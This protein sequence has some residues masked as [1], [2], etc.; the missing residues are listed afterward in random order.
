[1]FSGLGFSGWLIHFDEDEDEDEE[2]DDTH[3]PLRGAHSRTEC[4][5][6]FVRHL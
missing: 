6:I 2:D 5:P 3:S 4:A 1:M